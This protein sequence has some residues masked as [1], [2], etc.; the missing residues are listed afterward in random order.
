MKAFTCY[1]PE[2]CD[3]N[4]RSHSEMPSGVHQFVHAA[5]NSFFCNV[6]DHEKNYLELL[7]TMTFTDLFLV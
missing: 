5:R 4:A 3:K 6:W 2:S 1:T 7:S